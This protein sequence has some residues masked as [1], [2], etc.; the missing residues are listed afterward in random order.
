MM[1]F[2]GG[3]AKAFLPCQKNGL[4]VNLKYMLLKTETLKMMPLLPVS[5]LLSHITIR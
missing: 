4:T 2:A 1:P 3:S 5:I